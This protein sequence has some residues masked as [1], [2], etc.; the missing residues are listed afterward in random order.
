MIQQARREIDIVAEE[1][2]FLDEG[3]ARVNRDPHFDVKRWVSPTLA[4]D[5][6]A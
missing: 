3:F 4:L 6:T 2:V 5:R 1:I